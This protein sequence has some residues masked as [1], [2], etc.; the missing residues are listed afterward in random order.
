M[1]VQ[2]TNIASILPL[3][4]KRDSFPTFFPLKID[5]HD[6][7]NPPPQ[8][9]QISAYSRLLHA[10]RQTNSVFE[11]R[12][13][14]LEY[15]AE[16]NSNLSRLGRIRIWLGKIGRPMPTLL[17]LF[18]VAKLANHFCDLHQTPDTKINICDKNCYIFKTL[19][20]GK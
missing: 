16:K 9:S 6:A 13:R 14:L 11:T 18:T 7:R 8:P 15:R 20:V 5:D 1:Y 17:N 2:S 3:V 19:S 10:C 4:R 12:D